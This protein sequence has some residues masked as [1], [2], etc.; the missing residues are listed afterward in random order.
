MNDTESFPRLQMVREECG[1]ANRGYDIAK[2]AI[3]VMDGVRTYYVVAVTTSST[4]STSLLTNWHDG[5]RPSM[6][7]ITNP[8]R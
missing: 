2:G 7:E 4:S 5:C 8:E 6:S 3:G 1:L